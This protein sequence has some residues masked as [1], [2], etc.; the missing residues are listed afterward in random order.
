MEE[1]KQQSGDQV[2]AGT[3]LAKVGQAAVALRSVSAYEPRS[4]T[5]AYQIAAWFA[6]S[7]LIPEVNTPEKG[8]FIMATGAHLGIPA[9]TALRTISI[10]KGK[11]VLAADLMKAMCVARR[12]VCKHFRLVKSDD[13]AATYSAQRMEDPDPTVLT[14]TMEDAQRAKLAE[15][16]SDKS[17]N[18]YA[19]YPAVMLRRRCIAMLA[20]EVFPDVVLGVYCPEEADEIRAEAQVVDAEVVERAGA[21]DLEQRIGALL[22]RIQA[23][24][25]EEDLKA[26]V[27]EVNRDPAGASIKER[28]KPAYDARRA[29]LAPKKAG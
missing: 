29:D 7:N 28:L 8:F 18:N 4:A 16:G 15:R 23:A 27:A 13:K 25:T 26:V 1:A 21:D 19:K 22:E 14:F 5:E 2:P 6:K 17:D 3:A 9:T 10:V 24:Q 12:D 11:P 20:R